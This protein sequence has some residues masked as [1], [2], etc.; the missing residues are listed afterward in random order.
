M[1]DIYLSDFVVLSSQ[2]DLKETVK[3]IRTLSSRVSTFD[4]KTD[5]QQLTV[6]YFLLEDEILAE[7][8]SIL[9]TLENSV[10]NKVSKIK[11][12]FGSEAL[13][14]TVL[15]IGTT[16]IDI[17][18]TDLIKKHM[19]GDDTYTKKLVKHSIDS[20]A[21]FLA[22]KYGLN[23]LTMTIN[24][25][26]TSTANAILEGDNLIKSGVAECVIVLGI[27][28]NSS[29]MSSGFSAMNLLSMTTQKPFA[30]ERDGL[31]LGEGVAS[32]LLS[33][34]KSKHLLRGGY[35]NCDAESITG[36]SEGGE[37]FVRVMTNAM[38]NARVQQD[39]IDSIKVHATSTPASD[40]SE[41]NS[42]KMFKK[43]PRLSVIKPYIG[44]TVGVSGVLELSIFLTCLE[45]GFLPKFPS[46][47][48]HAKSK[49]GIN[50]LNYFGF[51]GNN[52]SLLVESDLT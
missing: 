34:Q 50:L 19:N 4:I 22:N 49:S 28:L 25:A 48:E 52:V 12:H 24:T 6:P 18:L 14:K 31:V 43:K 5:V 47:S 36:V 37:E 30:E 45:Q 39:E 40:L 35:S 42:L 20:Y 15:I 13:S 7:E 1:R 9:N 41:I 51:G 27:E 3:S 2:G 44:H 29:L 10:F 8:K 17:H 33:T 46:Q 16:M 26:C 21:D 38:S 32:L 11:K 23:E